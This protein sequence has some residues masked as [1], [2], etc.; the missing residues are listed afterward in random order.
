MSDIDKF[1]NE[2][3]DAQLERLAILAEELGEAQ[4]VIGK[5]IRHGYESYNPVVDTGMTNRRELERELGD[6]ALAV[7]MMTL[8]KDVSSAGIEA[9][10]RN[11][12]VSIQRW[13]HHQTEVVT[14]EPL[15]RQGEGRRGD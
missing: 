8:N 5:I 10:R 2:L 11:K 12:A 3:D 7:S 1:N 4:Q 6:I 14:N 15:G 9:R 13:L